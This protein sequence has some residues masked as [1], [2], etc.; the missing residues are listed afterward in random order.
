[1]NIFVTGGTGFIGSHLLRLLGRTNHKVIAL[2]RKGSLPSI[3]IGS[4][5][6][7][8]EKD[9]NK[10]DDLD[11]SGI[12]VFVHLAAVGV[13]PK[14]ASWHDLFQWNVLVLLGLL[15]HACAAG[16][17]RIVLTGSYAEYGLSAN[18]YDFIPANAALL[19]TSPYAASKAAGFVAA[20]AFAIERQI[21]LCYLRL[22][23]A[24]GE[25]QN[26][27]NFWPS[28][29]TAALS[30]VDFLM[31]PGKQVR[32]FISVEYVAKAILKAI[33]DHN[34]VQKEIPFVENV[35]TGHPV[36]ILEFAEKCWAEWGA[37]GRI[38]AGAK[39]YRANEP[40]RFVPKIQKFLF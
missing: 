26:K 35:G 5:P 17:G 4:Q 21:E 27:N 12:D 13:S 24:Y 1:M 25:G 18:M 9:L 19:P 16:V 40:M 32:D 15:E 8:L 29:C 14:I 34:L 22:F 20:N 2:R 39:P 3:D 33:E 38:I 30:G 31:T 36:T 7:W 10:L 6:Y 23:S 28:L 11:F 37:K